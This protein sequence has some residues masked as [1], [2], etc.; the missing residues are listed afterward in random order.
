MKEKWQN[1]GR[2]WYLGTTIFST[3]CFFEYFNHKKVKNKCDK[4]K[5][6]LPLCLP[7]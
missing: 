1:L 3:V 7:S 6:T 4:S 2:W 5:N